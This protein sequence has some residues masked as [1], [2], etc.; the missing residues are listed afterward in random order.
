MKLPCGPVGGSLPPTST[1]PLRRSADSDTRKVSR[2]K[3]CQK[4]CQ[5]PVA[6]GPE[7]APGLESE[8]RPRLRAGRLPSVSRSPLI[9]RSGVRTPLRAPAESDAEYDP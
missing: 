5:R 2:R 4:G 9:K 8:Y 1:L 6:M 3:E 7:T